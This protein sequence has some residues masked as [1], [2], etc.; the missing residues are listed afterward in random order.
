VQV[1]ISVISLSFIKDVIHNFYM[2]IMRKMSRYNN[3]SL[4]RVATSNSI[5]TDNIFM[6]I[7]K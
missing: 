6:E 5:I 4:C 3:C 1:G 7:S 2:T